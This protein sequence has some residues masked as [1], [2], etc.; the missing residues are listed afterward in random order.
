MLLNIWYT[1]TN[2]SLKIATLLEKNVT[3]LV[4]WTLATIA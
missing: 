2:V 4:C 3:T 1:G